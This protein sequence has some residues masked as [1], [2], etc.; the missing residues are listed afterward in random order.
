MPEWSP[1]GRHDEPPFYAVS[2]GLD[3]QK[4]NR[5]H[6]IFNVRSIIVVAPVFGSRTTNRTT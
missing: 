4:A 5:T 2:E 1:G 6:K 3:S